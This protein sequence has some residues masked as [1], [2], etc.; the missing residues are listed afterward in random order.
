MTKKKVEI[1]KQGRTHYSAEYKQQ[2]LLRA[3]KEGIPAVA[4]DLGLEPAQLYGWRAK[5]QQQGQD[6]Q[7]QQHMQSELARLKREL[8]R[9]E[10]EKAFLKKA[11]AYF[12]KQPK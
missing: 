9:V 3:V 12:A 8:A 10:E 11:A 5:S 6:A 2:A 4:Q 1:K 7:A